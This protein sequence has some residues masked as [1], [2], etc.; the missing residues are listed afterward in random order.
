VEMARHVPHAA[1][2]RMLRRAGYSDQQI[3][4]LLR[5][6][7]D[8]IDTERDGEVLFKHGISAGKLIE[9]MGAG[10]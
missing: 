6:L 7:P 2:E 3:K 5:K 4:G 1:A 9:R 10:P 8:P